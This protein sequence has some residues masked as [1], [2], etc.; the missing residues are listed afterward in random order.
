MTT[1]QDKHNKTVRVGDI[2]CLDYR[3]SSDSAHFLREVVYIKHTK[4]SWFPIEVG[5]MEVIG[6]TVFI[7]RHLEN[8][9]KMEGP[10]DGP[11]S[12]H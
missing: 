9:V 10:R 5:L 11:H 3:E 8:I 4:D 2:V 7:H 6:G 1:F 12:P